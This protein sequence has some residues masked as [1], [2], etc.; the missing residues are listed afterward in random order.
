MSIEKIVLTV[1]IVA[2][3]GFHACKK[4]AG[5]RELPPP[6]PPGTKLGLLK[7]MVTQSLPSPLYRFDYTDSGVTTDI[8]YASGFYIYELQWENKR[9]RRMINTFNQNALIYTYSNGRIMNIREVRTNNTTAWHYAF[10]YDNNQ[11]KEIRWYR[12]SPTGTDSILF[13]KVVLAF[14]SNGNLSRYDDYRDI[15]GT[16]EWIQSV[17]YDTYDNG[18]NVDDFNLL[19][20]VDDNLLYLPGIR[21]QLNNSKN[22]RITGVQNDYEITNSWQYQDGV[23]V[24]K[25]SKRKQ[26]RG[27]NAG[28]ELTS[29]TTYSY[30]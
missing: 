18:K 6:E 25:Q 24:L 26:V 19:K 9:L 12:I 5:Q 15:A 1:L 22:I 20:E 17:H 21:L 29:N 14:H 7:E 30:Y 4:T 2:C 13:R 11:V 8:N 16:L 10:T 23:P 27:S 3:A 28:M